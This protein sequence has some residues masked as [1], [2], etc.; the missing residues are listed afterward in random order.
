MQPAVSKRVTV[1]TNGC[2]VEKILR[3]S[4][5]S[6]ASTNRDVAVAAQQLAPELGPAFALVAY[7]DHTPCDLDAVPSEGQ[8]FAACVVGAARPTCTVLV[9]DLSGRSFPVDVRSDGTVAHIKEA[10]TASQGIMPSLQRLVLGGAT[11]I[12]ERTLAECQIQHMT[13]LHMLL[14]F[15]GNG[16]AEMNTCSVHRTEDTARASA[17]SVCAC[18]LDLREVRA[19]SMLQFCAVMTPLGSARATLTGTT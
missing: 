16:H 11:L 12:D 19:A 7:P 13:T 4:L 15:R 6:S 17:V 8:T 9:R 18:A 10:I 14:C 3:V 5:P 1:R 2:E